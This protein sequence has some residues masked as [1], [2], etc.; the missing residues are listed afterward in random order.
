[1]QEDI[2]FTETDTLDTLSRAQIDL[3]ANSKPEIFIM[4]MRSNPGYFDIERI[5]L[6]LELGRVE[7]Q[8]RAS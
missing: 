7:A 1:M 3:L 2:T 5:R 6:L 8:R 4:C